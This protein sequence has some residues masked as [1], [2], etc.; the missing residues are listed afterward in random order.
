[1][2]NIVV[3]ITSGYSRTVSAMV[4]SAFLSGLI[5]PF[6]LV[7]GALPALVTLRFGWRRSISVAVGALL[8]V[9]LFM[10][11]ATLVGWHIG[12]AA[13]LWIPLTQWLPAIFFA[14]ILRRMRSL[15][16]FMYVF[17]LAGAL[18]FFTVLAFFPGIDGYWREAY[19]AIAPMLENSGGLPAAQ[20]PPYFFSIFTG[21]LIS[22]FL[23]MWSLML[24]LGRWWQSLLDCPG[25]F[26]DEFTR[27]SIDKKYAL[28]I[29]ALLTV[30][31]A[32]ETP[33]VMQLCVIMVIPALVLHGVAVWHFLLGRC[34]SR[35]GH[36][37]FYVSLIFAMVVPWLILILVLTSIAESFARLRERLSEA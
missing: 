19:A 13:L 12:Y 15:A 16:H 3:S 37:L 31:L 24:L 20:A 8:A 29:I 4:V 32:A 25:G 21:V 22:S 33:I 9:T 23:M 35:M 1:M 34:Q 11:A 36:I 14:E 7:S 26:G 10:L 27:I 30:W 2:K 18:L 28:G 6:A 5:P 17:A